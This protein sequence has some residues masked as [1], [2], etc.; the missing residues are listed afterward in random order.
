[1]NSSSSKIGT[2]CCKVLLR[3][4]ISIYQCELAHLIFPLW[5]FT[6]R[7]FWGVW[8]PPPQNPLS[9]KL[10]DNVGQRIGQSDSFSA[11]Q[12]RIRSIFYTFFFTKTDEN[13]PKQQNFGRVAHYYIIIIMHYYYRTA[14]LYGVFERFWHKISIFGNFFK[15]NLPSA[16]KKSKC[17]TTFRDTFPPMALQHEQLCTSWLPYKPPPW[18]CIYQYLHKKSTRMTPS[19]QQFPNEHLQSIS[20]GGIVYERYMYVYGDLLSPKSTKISG[21]KTP[22]FEIHSFGLELYQNSNLSNL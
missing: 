5:L 20:V 10:S 19:K 14:H 16:S 12:T 13:W 17:Q 2:R 8:G 1:M 22:P 21:L 15:I 11:C 7:W 6:C 18:I 3:M 4:A 9:D